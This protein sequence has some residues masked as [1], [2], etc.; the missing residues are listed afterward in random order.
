MLILLWVFV[1]GTAVG[2]RYYLHAQRTQQALEEKTVV[3]ARLGDADFILEVADSDAE[4][5]QGLQ[6][7]T[8][9]PLHHGMLFEF[10][11]KQTPGFWM[12][13]TFIPLDFLWIDGHR[14]VDITTNVQPEPGVA[15]ANLHLYY[16]DM[17][18][19]RVIEIYAG[20]VNRYHIQVG[21]SVEIGN[22]E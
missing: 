1:A 17:P 15:D 13:N 9:L 22:A 3:Q 19:N 14:I 21:D 10:P 5:E 2:V 18:V 7:R 12:K 11:R 8:T 16:P 4:R 6:N 20:D